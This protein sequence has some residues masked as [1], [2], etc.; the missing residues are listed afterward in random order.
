MPADD[1]LKDEESLFTSPGILD[2]DYL[3]RLMPYREQQQKYLAEIIK[4]LPSLG[5]S[6]LIHGPPGIGKTACVRWIFR[7]L[8]ESGESKAVPVYIN[9]WQDNSMQ[10][11]VLRLCNQF[12]INISYRSPDELQG[13]VMQKLKSFDA[14]VLAFDEIDRMQDQTFL[15]HFVEELPH[16]SIFM[17]S[18][19]KDWLAN[20]DTRVRSRIMPEVLEFKPYDV[21][22]TRG[23]LEER[24]S[25]AFVPGVWEPDAFETVAAKCFAL[26][27]IRPGLALMKSSG[28]EAE[29]DA[30]RKIKA[31]HAKEAIKKLELKPAEEAGEKEKPGKKLTDFG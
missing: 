24:K 17:I 10:K 5:A 28:L 23:I 3:P 22:Q 12:G 6:V 15:Y 20:L 29:R 30:S 19:K 7:E 27:D 11:M 26:G 9:C 25:H 21:E 8:M 16:K 14:V 31:E 4:R 18:T 1:L 2:I 13:I